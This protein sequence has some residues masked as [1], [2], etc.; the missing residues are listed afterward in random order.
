MKKSTRNVILAVIIAVL[1]AVPLGGLVSVVTDNWTNFDP[2]KVNQDNLFYDEIDD[3]EIYDNYQIDAVAEGGIITLNGSIAAVDNTSLTFSDPIEIVTLTL[4]P[5][6]YTF[7]CFDKAAVK[8][9]FAVGQYTIA[10]QT[11]SWLAD[12]GKVPAIELGDEFGIVLENTITLE[13][14]VEV[15]FKIM[16][17]EG[18]ELDDVQAKPVI[19]EGE[20]EGSF[21]QTT[22]FA[23]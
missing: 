14:T 6:T 23:K 11:F 3:G 5:G 12:F 19:V 18:T 22:L 13:E 15:T 20:E 4:E 2:V 7:S 10:G 21:Y 1:V 17:A 9:Y 8:S 16:I